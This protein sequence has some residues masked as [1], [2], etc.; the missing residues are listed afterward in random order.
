MT[1]GRSASVLGGITLTSILATGCV[2]IVD[3]QCVWSCPPTVWKEATAEIAI[4]P[5]RLT[6]MEVQ[7]HNGEID[8]SGQPAGTTTAS[9]TVRKKAGGLTV[10]DAEEAMEAIDVYSERSADGAQRLGWR[11]KGVK[12][13]NWQTQVSFSI[14]APGNL[15]FDAES[16]NGAV[17]AAGVVG[18]VRVVTHNGRVKI[19]SQEGALRAETHNGR[20][21]AEYAGPKITL[22]TH[23]GEIEAN[24]SRCGAIA[25]DITTHNGAVVI[26]VG[27]STSASLNAETDNGRISLDAPITESSVGRTR[28]K[29]KLGV[30]G[31]NLDIVTHNGNIRIKKAAG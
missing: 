10:A 12:K 8:F 28:L 25:G 16:H 2:F 6:A 15:R 4:D 9:A 29:G 19:V 27:A 7:T 18:E 30:G 24:L 14:S 23:N 31:E 13:N 22:E 3:G 5:N 20:I 17:S 1:N 26:A 21:E 11:W